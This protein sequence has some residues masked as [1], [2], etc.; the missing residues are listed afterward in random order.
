MKLTL[1]FIFSFLM[2]ALLQ[3]C[4]GASETEADGSTTSESETPNTETS[5]P[6]QAESDTTSP[7]EEDNTNNDGFT[8]H[9]NN[10]VVSLNLGQED[11]NAWV[12]ND[13]FYNDASKIKPVMTKI[14]EKFHDNFD[15]IFFVLN[16]NITPDSI[17]YSGLNISG[18]NSIE[19]IGK[20]IRP[21]TSTEFGSSTKLQS[22]MQ[23]TK[24]NGIS[25]GPTLH[26]LMHNWGNF[27]LE[28]YYV[29]S[30]GQESRSYGHWGYSSVGGQLGGFEL[31]TLQ[32][33][34]DGDA[35]KYQAHYGNRSNFGYNANGGN[36]LPYS[37]LELYLMGLLPSSD[38]PD[39]VV[40]NGLTQTFE[41]YVEG[42]FHATTKEIIT[43]NDIIEKHGERSPS[44][45]NSQT[46]F[47]LLTV[48]LTGS[49]LSTE[50]WTQ[51]DNDVKWFSDIIETDENTHLYNFYQATRGQAYINA[52]IL[53]E[54][55]R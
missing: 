28:S 34:I 39:T 11:Y 15:F 45:L 27:I 13:Y 10:R 4:Q 22:T 17:S 8:L 42:I 12:E 26:E 14:Y 32:E 16:E 49:E 53:A 3:G 38:V 48:V 35:N 54:D 52:E 9:E 37:E 6:E 44:Y 47:K 55:I 30:D 43:I 50:E 33:N 46:E 23:L 51:V 29:K 36:G 1:S 31:S 40:F 18:V 41:E 21:E 25:G 7:N 2:L 20:Y 24:L 5:S 19:G